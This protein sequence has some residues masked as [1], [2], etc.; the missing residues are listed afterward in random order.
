MLASQFSVLSPY[1]F[2]GHKKG[3]YF[4][5]FTQV[6]MF[7]ISIWVLGYNMM[8]YDV[9]STVFASVKLTIMRTTVVSCHLPCFLHC[10]VAQRRKISSSQLIY[11]L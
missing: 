9:I 5:A 1:L 4:L 11:Y 6:A 2:K 3:V 8:R 7:S 10:E